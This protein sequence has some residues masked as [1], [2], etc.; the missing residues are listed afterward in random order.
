MNRWLSKKLGASLGFLVVP[1]ALGV[2]FGGIPSTPAAHPAKLAAAPK[3]RPAPAPAS[4][5]A[6]E[7]PLVIKRIL[8]VPDPFRHGDYV[9]DDA[10]VPEGPVVITVDL[11]AQVLSIFRSG[12]EIG[13]AVILYG[14]DDKPTPLGV[15]PI[16][17][18][19]ADH[20]SSLYGAPMPYTL[21][22][23]SDGVSIHGSEVN[24]GYGTHGCVG[25][26]VA[27]ARKLFNAVKPG[28]R[29]YI[30]NGQMMQ[31]GSPL[32]S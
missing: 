13:T 12:Y 18:K 2:H 9:W 26:P 28:D 23:T 19:D 5:P 7:E 31:M 10:G 22:L 16:L 20:V 1:V 24:W 17:A 11:K 15:F 25:V 30:T 29:V 14:A 27:F 4:A 8:D 6:A 21:R 3:S 32:A